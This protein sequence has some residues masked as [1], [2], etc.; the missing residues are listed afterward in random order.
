MEYIDYASTT[1]VQTQLRQAMRSWQTVLLTGQAKS[2]K[3][4]LIQQ[5]ATEPW[6][7]TA[8]QPRIVVASL[9]SPKG[10]RTGQYATAIAGV[11]FTE[12]CVGLARCSKL[13]DSPLIHQQKQW[14]RRPQSLVGDQ[15]FASLYAFVRNELIRLRVN[16]LVID[17]AHLLDTFTLERLLDCQREFHGQ[18]ALV[19]V[20]TRETS[21]AGGQ[22]STLLETLTS[23]LQRADP[24]FLLRPDEQTVQTTILAALIKRFTAGPSSSLSRDDLIRMRSTF[25]EA[26]DGHW[27]MLERIG[28]RMEGECG[29]TT[30]KG[31]LTKERWQRI[32]PVR[33]TG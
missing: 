11:T 12:I 10:K 20:E 31:Q 18:L 27:D 19:F 24:L 15:Q 8:M 22:L 32:V 13:Y 5:V 14:Y 6:P 33:K 3:S 16:A 30:P 17:E 2:G 25:W 21:T 1:E 23:P 28:I 26:T 29:Q 4:R 9:W 7:E